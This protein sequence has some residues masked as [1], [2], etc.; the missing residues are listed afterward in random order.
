MD[1]AC[2]TYEG[3]SFELDL[4]PR[5]KEPVWILGKEYITDRGNDCCSLLPV[6]RKFWAYFKTNRLRGRETKL[7]KFIS[8]HSPLN[9]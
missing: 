3:V 1:I 7:M 2:A 8:K 6:Y 9:R 4:F 5:T